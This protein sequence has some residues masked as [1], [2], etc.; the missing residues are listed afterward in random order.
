[1]QI[2]F[3]N[4]DKD[5]G[6]HKG[7]ITTLEKH[8]DFEISPNANYN[9]ANQDSPNYTIHGKGVHGRLVELGAGWKKTSRSGLS[10]MTLSMDAP[11][12]SSN[13]SVSAFTDKKDSTKM[14]IAYSRPTGRKPANNE[15]GNSQTAQTA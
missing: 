3:I 11:E 7:Q 2:G 6:I 13:L 12:W 8:I 14:N 10:Y 4:L 5:T 15:A 1:M 9:P